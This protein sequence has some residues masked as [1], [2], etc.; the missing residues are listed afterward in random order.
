M[1]YKRNETILFNI[2]PF[3]EIEAI[4]LTT[5]SFFNLSKENQRAL[6]TF[7]KVLDYKSPTQLV[8]P[9][10]FTPFLQTPLW[11]QKTTEPFFVLTKQTGLWT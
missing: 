5:P 11:V 3:E 9:K 6:Q 7:E 10:D 8:L 1:I 2:Y 4:I